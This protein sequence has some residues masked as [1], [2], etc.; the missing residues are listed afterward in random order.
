MKQSVL[1]MATLLFGV[2]AGLGLTV[3]QTQSIRAQTTPSTKPNILFVLTDDMRAS[4]LS[5]MPETTKLLAGGGVKF[6]RAFVTNSLCCPSR[7]TILRGQYAHNHQIL[8]NR[9]PMGGFEKFRNLGREDSTIATW[10]DGAGYDTMFIGKY[11]NGYDNTTYVPQ[12]WDEWHG[13]LG[14]YVQSDT[15]RINENGQINTYAR[16]QIHDTDLFADKAATFLQSTAGGAPFFMYLST[17]APH[18]PTFAAQ[19]H[20]GM[21]SDV[22]LPNPPSFN[23]A[24][25][26]DKPA[27]VRNT[28]ILTS[29]EVR[30]LGQRYRQRLRSLQSVDEMVGRLVGVLRQ[31]G[32]LSNTYIVFTSDN[33]L[34][35]GEHRIN[36]KKWTAYEEAIHVPL[37]VRGPGVPQGVSRSQMAL[38][39][40]LAPT[41]AS[42]AG[43]TPPSFVDGRSLSPLLSTSPPSSWR[44][45]FLVEH[46]LD[47]N[48]DP[49]AATIPDY[50]ALRT[51]RYLFVRYSTG[52]RELY[53]RSNDPY[54][55]E[56]L[57]DSATTELKGRLASRLD[58]LEGCAAQSCRSAEN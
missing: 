29:E 41:F 20:Q 7:A 34:H 26:A 10:L 16:S 57:H 27:W 49:Y 32:E 22:S 37:L 25:V 52:E 21:F 54:E 40:D 2:L 33:G 8:S 24:D 48:G 45:A 1:L 36:K 31:T 39:N 43:V 18:T 58:A 23:E 11:F 47:E 44:S 38:N 30:Q 42:W 17:N 4:D 9:M 12:G 3:A 13:Y 35:L 46:W 6:T 50:K 14:D 5:Y 51:G 56:S 19:R 55:L 15:Y 53:D 28:P